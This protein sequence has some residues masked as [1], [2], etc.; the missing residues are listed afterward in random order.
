M[1]SKSLELMKNYIG[2]SFYDNRNNL[3]TVT[4]V[5]GDSAGFYFHVVNDHNNHKS[6]CTLYALLSMIMFRQKE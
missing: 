4:D 5:E 2:L 3:L 1:D 6:V